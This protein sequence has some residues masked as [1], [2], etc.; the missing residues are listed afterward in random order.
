MA[1]AYQYTGIPYVWGSMNPNVGFDCSSFVKYMYD[2]VGI[3]GVPQSSAAQR[4]AGIQVPAHQARP[5]DIVW[6]P[7]HTAIYIGNGQV[8]GAWN[9]N[10]PS[11][12]G[13]IS[14]FTSTP[15]FIR[16]GV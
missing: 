12:T 4:Y 2:S 6:A 8:I 3:H 13:P 16:P 15:I 1:T 7:G 11:G 5:G 10:M 9:P 14:W